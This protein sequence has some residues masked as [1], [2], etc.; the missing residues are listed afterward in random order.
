MGRRG[1]YGKTYGYKKRGTYKSGPREQ[2]AWRTSTALEKSSIYYPREYRHFLR[3]RVAA[4]PFLLLC[5]LPVAALFLFLYPEITAFITNW[6]GDTIRRITGIRPPVES[7]QFLEWVGDIHYLSLPG[8]APGFF[9]AVVS[10]LVCVAVFIVS[11][12]TSLFRPLMIYLCLGAFAQFVSSLFFILVPEYFPYSLTDYSKLYMEQQVSLWLMITLIV[13]ISIALASAPGLSRI[14]AF[15][16]CIIYLLVFGCVRY[17]LYLLVLHYF[18]LLYMASLFFT[19][20]VLF[21]FLQMV[22]IYAVFVRYQSSRI[23]TGKGQKI[24]QWS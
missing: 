21:D 16:A 2:R 8:P 9:H 19:L 14:V 22:T 17:V 10:A 11:A 20:G 4:I 3:F 15:Y 5:V 23:N 1:A 7:G 6:G 24:W 12:R 13:G 18:S